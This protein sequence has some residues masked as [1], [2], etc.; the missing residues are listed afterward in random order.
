MTL[1]RG[2]TNENGFKRFQVILIKKF[3]QYGCSRNIHSLLGYSL[4]YHRYSDIDWQRRLAYC[5]LQHGKRRGAKEG[6]HCTFTY[7]H[8]NNLLAVSRVCS[9]DSI[10]K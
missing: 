2:N 10:F 5:W 4:L 9:A 3:L 1:R 8:G 7:C 6:K